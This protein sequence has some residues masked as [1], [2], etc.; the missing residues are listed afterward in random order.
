MAHFKARLSPLLKGYTAVLI[1]VVAG[2]AVF[3]LSRGH[4]LIAISLLLLLGGLLL[5]GFLSVRGYDVGQGRLVIQRPG[6]STGI[7]LSGLAE[8]SAAPGIVGSS[9]SLWSTRGLFG[10]IG[11]GHK[12]GIGTYSAYVTDPGKAVLL[13]FSSGKK[14]VI[15]P[16]S[17]DDF[18]ATV[19]VESKTGTSL[20]SGKPTVE[21]AGS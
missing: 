13:H 14:V 8:A 3:S 15:S 19:A 16:E 21:T 7:D 9:L 6:W 20:R 18:L 2:A 10:F 4:A 11:Y 1:L 5:L 17:P 12:R